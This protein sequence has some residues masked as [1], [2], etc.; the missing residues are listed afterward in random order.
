MVD[1]HLDA[2]ASTI[3]FV[4]GIVLALDAFT[5][6]WKTGVV[7]GWERLF[8]VLKAAGKPDILD[9]PSGK[10]ATSQS[11]EDWADRR[12]RKLAVFGFLLLALGFALDIYSKVAGNPSLFK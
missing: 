12:T 6:K 1:I 11:G 4:A 10:P 9:D 3:N 2:L 5:A 7:R 8:E